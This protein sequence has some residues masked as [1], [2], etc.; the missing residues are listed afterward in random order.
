MKYC[1]TLN[2]PYALSLSGHTIRFGTTSRQSLGIVVVLFPTPAG[3]ILFPVDVIEFELPLLFGLDAMRK[4]HIT[5]DPTS[6]KARLTDCHVPLFNIGNHIG[7]AWSPP[8]VVFEVYTKAELRNIH[9]KLVHP[10]ALKLHTLLRKAQYVELH[11]EKLN[12]FKE[13]SK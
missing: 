9:K 2:I 4:L 13:I 12:I 8:K 5:I 6:M 1:A 10:S 3:T 11:P 7:L